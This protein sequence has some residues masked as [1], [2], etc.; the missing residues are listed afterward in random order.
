MSSLSTRLDLQ[1]ITNVEHWIQRY[2]IDKS[3]F[4]L[5]KL[6]LKGELYLAGQLGIHA[7]TRQEGLEGD[8]LVH[9]TQTTCHLIRVSDI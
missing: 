5:C 9:I 3:V 7:I 6:T 1:L 8:H 4:S 2:F